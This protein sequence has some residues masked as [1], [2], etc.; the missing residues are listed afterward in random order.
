MHHPAVQGAVFLE[1]AS[2]I[3]R[4]T[5]LRWLQ[6]FQDSPPLGY[7]EAVKL[8]ALVT[9]AVKRVPLI[10]ARRPC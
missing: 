4:T 6:L 1:G 3:Q 8:E 9:T 5:Q 2:F 10:I 7:L